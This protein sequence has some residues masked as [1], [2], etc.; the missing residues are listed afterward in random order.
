MSSRDALLKRIDDIHSAIERHKTV[1]E[2]D[3]KAFNDL[4][5]SLNDARAKLNT[6][7]PVAQLPVEILSY[8]FKMCDESWRDHYSRA[9]ASCAP[10]LLLRV[11]RSWR[12]IV[13]SCPLLWTSV[14]FNT[15]SSGDS[16]AKFISAWLGRSRALPLDI[17]LSGLI[18]VGTEIALEQHASRVRTLE[19]TGFFHEGT[20]LEHMTLFLSL[21]ILKLSGPKKLTISDYL[22]ILH[23]TPLLTELGLGSY[24]SSIDTGEG[25]A[26]VVHTSLRTL[27]LILKDKFVCPS[28][29]LSHLTLP[30]LESLTLRCADSATSG[31]LSK[32]FARS[33]PPLKHLNITGVDAAMDIE[34]G[35]L[36]LVPTLADLVMTCEG[37]FDPAATVCATMTS[38]LVPGLRRLR[39]AS[40]SFSVSPSFSLGESPR[41][42]VLLWN[43]SRRCPLL[44]VVRFGYHSYDVPQDI[45]DQLQSFTRG[46]TLHVHI[47]AW[48][49]EVNRVPC[50]CS[51]CG[52]Q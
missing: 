15:H 21:R 20:S 44:E 49:E 25:L 12:D 30:A 9:M 52:L 3:T 24:S 7:A 37:W 17:W 34:L 1:S 27:K 8:I 47:G 14:C 4:I 35:Y 50:M 23:S 39:V 48:F 29:I 11:C 51:R 18:S 5:T 16:Y 6:P 2:H 19:I 36:R 22:R 42:P 32:F 10:L 46:G 28:S 31:Y 33:S 26:A 40:P 43:C 38:D 41:L 13:V 45:H